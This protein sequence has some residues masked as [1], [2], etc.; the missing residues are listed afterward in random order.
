M[1]LVESKIKKGGLVFRDL[2]EGSVNPFDGGRMVEDVGWVPTP[3]A[4]AASCACIDSSTHDIV[5]AR[6]ASTFGRRARR[7]VFLLHRVAPR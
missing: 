3:T 7:A 1:R 2:V 5:S 4:T 6:N